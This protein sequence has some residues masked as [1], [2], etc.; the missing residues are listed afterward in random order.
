MN[1][2]Q[3]REIVDLARPMSVTFHRAFDMTP[4]PFEALEQIIKAGAER[5]LTSGQQNKA[6]DGRKLITE[7]IK[8]AGNRIVIMPGSGI[9]YGNIKTM[10]E[11]GAKEFHLSGIGRVASNMKYRREDVFMGGL[12][13]IPEYEIAISDIEKIRKIVN[14]ENRFIYYPDQD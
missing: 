2:D 3:T 9:N 7:L 4:D 11:T 5:I 6:P 13:Q 10:M 1:T 12:S 8:K 14:L